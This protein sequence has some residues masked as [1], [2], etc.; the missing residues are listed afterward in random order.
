MG[1]SA[2]FAFLLITRNAGPRLR[3]TCQSLAAALRPGDHVVVLDT[4]SEDDSIVRLRRFLAEDGWG[5]GVS[6]DILTLS[7]HPGMTNADW[8]RLARTKA[9]ARWCIPLGGR[10]LVQGEAM[11]AL[12][13]QLPD[14]PEPD[15]LVLANRGWWLSG[16][17]SALP[18][19]DSR[20]WPQEPPG[21]IA[22]V[23]N[24]ARTLAPDPARLVF[25]ADFA[26]A[27]DALPLSGLA[28]QP[29]EKLSLEK[30]WQSYDAAIAAAGEIR[31]FAA[32]IILAPMGQNGVSDGLELVQ[33][34]LRALP[35]E[36]GELEVLLHRLGDLMAVLEPQDGLKFLNEMKAVLA[37]LPRRLRARACAHDSPAGQLLEALRKGGTAGAMPHLSIGFAARERA[38]MRALTGEIAQLREDVDLALPGEDYL[39]RLYDWVRRP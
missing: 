7:D 28:P 13:R 26:A 21:E 11:D 6:H 18:C 5:D 29:P 38:H 19:P 22:A 9:G 4:G 25:G 31:F 34:R 3:L 17:H 27:P 23:R 10:D 8:V 24:V 1:N 32:P 12:R 20:R 15:L 30:L 36:G 39:L 2:S 35:P 14:P 33:A 16:P 37:A